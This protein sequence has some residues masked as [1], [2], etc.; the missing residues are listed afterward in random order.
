[1]MLTGSH[2]DYCFYDGYI[3]GIHYVF[4]A[5]EPMKYGGYVLGYYCY[6]VVKKG[7]LCCMVMMPSILL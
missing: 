3:Y 6:T 2:N 4:F 1:M 5:G 7:E